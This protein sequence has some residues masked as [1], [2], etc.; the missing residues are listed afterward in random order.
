MVQSDAVA[1]VEVIQS[2]MLLLLEKGCSHSWRDDTVRYAAAPGEML[3]SRA[4]SPVGPAALG[5]AGAAALPHS[6]ARALPAA[7][8]GRSGQE[9]R[10]GCRV[11]ETARHTA[12][13]EEHQDRGWHRAPP[14]ITLR[15]TGTR[16]GTGRGH[17]AL[18]G[19]TA[20]HGH[21]ALPGITASHGHQ[22]RDW[23]RALPGF[24]VRGLLGTPSKGS[25]HWED[26]GHSPEHKER[27]GE[28]RGINLARSTGVPQGSQG[29]SHC[30]GTGDHDKTPARRVGHLWGAGRSQGTAGAHRHYPGP[31][32]SG[33]RHC[34]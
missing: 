21:R 19:I 22:E 3:L 2:E 34:L 10:G 31:A 5:D 32:E 12:G 9:T 16:S 28:A 30:P 27:A 13:F 8:T 15:V 24:T 17:L 29:A 26:R 25:E 14:A 23:H 18:P 20:S 1:P 7:G 6:T 4:P 11:L 33:T